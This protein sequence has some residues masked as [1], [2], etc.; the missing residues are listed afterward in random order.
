MVLQPKLPVQKTSLSAP[1]RTQRPFR[2][3][4]NGSI[5]ALLRLP[6]RR[7]VRGKLHQI[8]TTGGLLNLHL[9]L[10]EKLQLELIFH[11]AEATIRET[12]V[13]M[14]PM[15]ATH[16]WMQPFRFVDMTEA[17]REVLERNLKALLPP[18]QE[19]SEA[20]NARRANSIHDPRVL[21]GMS[22]TS[23]PTK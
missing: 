14:F 12:V 10:D 13:M 23:A 22:S 7:Q 19:E 1:S 3:K 2:V 18:V 20:T 11:L 16:G 21:I 5:L 4:L 17:N 8:S 9:P 6:N 15:W